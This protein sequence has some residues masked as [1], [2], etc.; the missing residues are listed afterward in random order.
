MTELSGTLAGVG[1]PAIVRFLQG[2]KKTG[3]L[4]LTQDDWSG[5]VDFVAGDVTNATL[6]SRTGLPA[7]DGMLELFPD[8]EFTFEPLP[9]D[10][11]TLEWTVRLS[12]DDLL[13]RLDQGAERIARNGRRL[14][15]P[16]AVPAQVNGDG[17]GEEPLPL[18]RGTLQTLLAVDGHRSVREIVAVR[19]SIESL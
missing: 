5:Q 10:A 3:R 18:D 12:Q 2:L 9:S 17:S 1:L 19:Q 4:C 13:A 8:A 15:R 7:L 6:G 14:P 16:D 11:P